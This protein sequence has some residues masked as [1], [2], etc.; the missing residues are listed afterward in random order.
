MYIFITILI[1]I[2]IV[3]FILVRKRPERIVSELSP[4]SF[5]QDMMIINAQ[6]SIA[7]QISK[8]DHINLK[9]N[10]K[11]LQ[12]RFYDMKITIVRTDGSSKD[13]IYRGSEIK[14][15]DIAESL[16]SHHI[17]CYF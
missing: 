5:A 17:K 4:F 8:I 16:G 11:S 7:I 2:S 12:N 6:A 3:T 10:P 14:P 1:S 15:E 13:I 9:Y